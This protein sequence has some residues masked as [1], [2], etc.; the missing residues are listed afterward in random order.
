MPQRILIVDDEVESL[1]I[2][3]RVLQKQYDVCTAQRVSDALGILEAGPIDCCLTDLV[4]PD[5]EGL[6]FV[7]NLAA[8]YPDMPLLVMSG[9]ATVKMGVQA[10]MAG[11]VDFIEKPILNLDILSV[12]VKKALTSHDMLIENR[13]LREELSNLKRRNFVG[14]SP[15]IQAVLG[16]VHKV[17]PLNSTILVEGETGTGKELIAR[18]IHDNSPRSN[19]PFVAVNCG[20]IPEN[21]LESLLFGHMKGAFTGATSEAEGY[22]RQADGGT[23]FLDE[24]GETP[25][26]F[27]VKLLRAL[28]E[29]TIRRVGEDRDIDIDV[30]IIAATNRSLADEMKQGNFRKDLYFRLHV[31]KILIPP[32]RERPDDIPLL[33]AHFLKL[34]IKENNIEKLRISKEAM[35]VLKKSRLEGNVREVQNVIEHSAALCRSDIIWVED[36]PDYIR[37]IDTG[38]DSLSFSGDYDSAKGAFERLYFTKLLQSTGS[39]IT[40][41]AEVSGL[42]RQHIY[43]KLKKLNIDP[44]S[45]RQ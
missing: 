36:M 38:E 6:E 27:Q 9:K 39:V 28:Q 2:C 34:F 35:A 31:I 15:Q 30:R 33:A 24:I 3:Q 45:M 43:L 32:L 22:F 17:A 26:P 5:V 19:K 40:R 10:M 1:D 11:A 16:I 21:L 4:M 41:A 8:S 7:Q 37:G 13:R 25:L 42:T 14:N 20:A 44:G 18:M 29:K 23:L 12:M